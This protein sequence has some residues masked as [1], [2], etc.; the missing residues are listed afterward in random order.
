MAAL[1]RSERPWYMFKEKICTRYSQLLKKNLKVIWAL[2]GILICNY[3]TT[4]LM[5][6]LCAVKTALRFFSE[7]SIY[8]FMQLYFHLYKN[9]DI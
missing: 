6:Q 3:D 4:I 7:L 9:Y 2:A 5:I 8:S 1:F